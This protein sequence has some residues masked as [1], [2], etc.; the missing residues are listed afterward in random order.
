MRGRAPEG[1]Q[2]GEGSGELEAE[3]AVVT[4]QAVGRA[5]GIGGAAEGE[6]GSDVRGAGGGVLKGD[7]AVEGGFEGSPD[8]ELMPAGDGH[9]LDEG[10]LGFRG[11]MELLH[12]AGEEGEEAVFG[13]AFKNHGA[14]EPGGAGFAARGDGATGEGSVAAGGFDLFLGSHEYL[15]QGEDRAGVK[16]LGGR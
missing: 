10:E 4:E 14:G 2:K 15:T 11:G 8:A 3:G 13:F 7:V 1:L 12:E 9:G 16:R 6:D 5:G